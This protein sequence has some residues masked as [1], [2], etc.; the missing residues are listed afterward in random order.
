MSTANRDTRELLQEKFHK[1]KTLQEKSC[2]ASNLLD[3]IYH[4]TGLGEEIQ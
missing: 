4:T 1:K 3:G 2:I